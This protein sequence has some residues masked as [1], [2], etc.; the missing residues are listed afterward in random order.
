[1]TKNGANKKQTKGQRREE[2]ERKRDDR[3]RRN[4][5]KKERQAK[6]YLEEDENFVSFS[7]QLEALGLKIK[8][9]PGDGNCLF[10]SLGDQLDGDHT[11]HA[12]HRRDTVRYMRAHRSDF[13]PFMEDNVSFDQHLQD[14]SKLGTYGGN[15][16][17]VAFA[18]YH[19]VNI[20]IHQLNEPRWV[21][22][23]ADYCKD[24]QVRE[25]HISYHNGE[26]YSS[27]RHITDNSTEPAWIKHNP[28]TFAAVASPAKT[29]PSGKKDKK[30]KEKGKRKETISTTCDDNVNHISQG[31]NLTAEELVMTATG[32]KDLAMIAQTLEDNAYDVDAS[33]N[34]IL[35]LMYVAEETGCLSKDL[36]AT[37]TEPSHEHVQ[38][39]DL[40]QSETDPGSVDKKTE[41]CETKDC[42]AETCNTDNSVKLESRTKEGVE[43]FSSPSTGQ[44]EAV[45]GFV[46]N[47][48]KT[49]S[50]QSDQKANKSY[51]H[52][53][54]RPK[55]T[56]RSKNRQ[57]SSNVHLSN[58]KRKELAK[59]EKKKRREERRKDDNTSS[60]LDTS[61]VT[62][63]QT[64]TNTAAV[65]PDLGLL[66]I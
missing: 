59:Q 30:S 27:V 24:G 16:S 2:L 7:N 22:Y 17:I 25:L 31:N 42:T 50:Q 29:Q 6:E 8:D 60:C 57:D 1:M 52:Q 4:A 56:D 49:L 10:R 62:G 3:V 21:I 46:E 61:V 15:D 5:L 65:V 44:T 23:G 53:G 55:V 38:S 32:C 43:P 14:I 37:S 19:G 64:A 36:F 26:H 20:V 12:Q 63:E 35:Q 47:S 45:Q 41:D 34:Y 58:K 51:E 28:T 18:R 11:T 9:I 66:A 48:G 39:C 40:P 54:A 33:I 13:E